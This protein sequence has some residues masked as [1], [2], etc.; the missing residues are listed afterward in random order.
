MHTHYCLCF[1]TNVYCLPTKFGNLICYK[2]CI[3]LLNQ[4]LCMSLVSYMNMHIPIALC[5]GAKRTNKL[6]EY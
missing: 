6:S 4:V 3:Q 5:C 1:G 2:L